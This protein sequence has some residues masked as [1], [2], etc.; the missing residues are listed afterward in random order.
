MTV[1]DLRREPARLDEVFAA[2]RSRVVSGDLPAAGLA[3]GDGQGSIRAEVTGEGG[4]PISTDTNFFL[5]S[6]TK[7][8]VATAFMELVEDGA[9]SLHDPV[10]RWVPAMEAGE[11]AAVTPWHVL[12]HTSG[13]VDVP[14]EELVRNRPSAA[15]MLRAVVEQPLRFTPGTRWDYNSASFYLLTAIIERVTGLPY[16]EYIHERLARPLNLGLTFDPRRSRRPVIKVHGAG[17]DNRVVRWYV[18]RYLAGAALPGG[19]LFGNLSDLAALGAA[20]VAP[21]PHGGRGSFP[22]SAETVALMAQ[23]QTHGIPGEV[24]GEDRAVHVGLGWA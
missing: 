12:T 17:V 21:R 10:A 18:V 1:D 23:D 24:A 15:Q 3:V 14:P 11:K 7:P 4:R 22:L 13:V 2:L 9:V 6:I 19:G 16:V 5:A 8:I 20:L